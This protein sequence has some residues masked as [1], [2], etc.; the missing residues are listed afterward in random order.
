[1]VARTSF[2]ELHLERLASGDLVLVDFE[3]FDTD[4]SN[5]AATPVLRSINGSWLNSPY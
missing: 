1:M 2:N 3:F 4:D 5:N